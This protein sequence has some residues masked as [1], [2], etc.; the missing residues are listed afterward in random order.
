VTI[1]PHRLP[2]DGLAVD[3]RPGPPRHLREEPEREG[4]RREVTITEINE[5][6]REIYDAQP[7][8]TRCALCPWTFEGTAAG[9]RLAAALHRRDAHGT[10]TPIREEFGVEVQCKVEGCSNMAPSHGRYAKLCATHRA[11]GV[12]EESS[13]PSP[14]RNRRTVRS[15]QQPGAEPSN[16]SLAAAAQA[17]DARLAEFNAAKAAL[18]DA[19]ENLRQ[20]TEAVAA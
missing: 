19:I 12:R 17:V 4:P 14:A 7:T 1:R 15:Q 6:L 13:A 16:G 20:A 2:S 3:T 5:Q 18:A 9:G 10:E 8:V 11:R